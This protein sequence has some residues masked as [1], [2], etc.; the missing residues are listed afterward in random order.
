M[1]SHV[2]AGAQPGA[3]AIADFNSDGKL[4]LAVT[5]SIANVN[6]LLGNGDG[7]F[8]ASVNYA[9]RANPSSVSLEI[10]M[11]TATGFGRGRPRR[12]QRQPFTRKRRQE[13]EVRNLRIL[14]KIKA[15]KTNESRSS[16]NGSE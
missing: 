8:Q 9:A 13:G 12:Q 14:R 5:Q 7:T 2:P 16:A 10:S 1:R 4:D 6:V 3:V 15:N 11:V